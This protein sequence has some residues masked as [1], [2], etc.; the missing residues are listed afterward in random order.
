MYIEN[1]I[2][3]EN[4]RIIFKNFR[5]ERTEYN[6]AGDRNFN[7][8]IP[9]AEWARQLKEDGWNIHVREPRGEGEE[10]EY[11]L[12]VSVAFNYR[13]PKIVL[14]SRGRQQLL[15]EESV[16]I[17][18][19]ADIANIDLSVRPYNW[20]S[21]GKTGVKAYLKTMYVT[22]EEDEFE[23]KYANDVPFDI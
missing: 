22:L 9:D 6:R 23:A 13:P 3:I 19:H 20:E 1:N 8:I 7:V 4:A 11:R 12:P 15:D 17:L 16:G 18:D 10:P 5:G 21:Q 14:I 2:N